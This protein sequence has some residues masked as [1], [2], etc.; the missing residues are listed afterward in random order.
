MVKFEHR[1]PL[2]SL[3][4]E[5][6]EIL[7]VNPPGSHS[8]LSCTVS[9]QLSS[10]SVSLRKED[11]QEEVAKNNFVPVPS[12]PW[13]GSAGKRESQSR[14]GPCRQAGGESSA[15]DHQQGVPLLNPGPEGT[16]EQSCGGGMV[17]VQS[18]W[19]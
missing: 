14:V 18:H 4:S 16:Q 15:V 17:P 2:N 9:L 3:C 11:G 10:L 8:L 6:K 1:K 12:P 5:A 13:D 19:H 7:L